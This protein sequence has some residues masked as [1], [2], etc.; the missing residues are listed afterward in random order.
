MATRPDKAHHH[1]DA[2]PNQPKGTPGRTNVWQMLDPLAVWVFVLEDST[3]TLTL[4]CKTLRNLWPNHGYGMIWICASGF[5]QQQH[6]Q[7]QLFSSQSPFLISAMRRRRK[8][9]WSPSCGIL[10]R[11][12]GQGTICEFQMGTATVH[13]RERDD[14]ALHWN[15][16]KPSPNLDGLTRVSHLGHLESLHSELP[17]MVAFAN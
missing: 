4:F 5:L 11:G 16:W 9:S 8:V 3:S 12:Q 15:L 14:S 7:L 10:C 2:G 6:H 13:H 1:G 17:H